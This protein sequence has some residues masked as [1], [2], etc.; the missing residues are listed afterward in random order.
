MLHAPF[1]QSGHHPHAK[2]FLLSVSPPP[3]CKD[4]ILPLYHA[5][6]TLLSVQIIKKKIKVT[7]LAFLGSM[8]YLVGNDENG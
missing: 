4:M 7:V 8:F 3:R 6:K 5:L 2:D 1:N